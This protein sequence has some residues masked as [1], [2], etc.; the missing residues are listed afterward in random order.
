[1]MMVGKT[2]VAVLIGMLAGGTFAY[3]GGMIAAFVDNYAK[4]RTRE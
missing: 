4:R 3:L 2:A 1:M